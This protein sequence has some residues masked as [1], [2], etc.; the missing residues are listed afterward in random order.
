[1]F[2]MPKKKSLSPNLIMAISEE[3]AEAMYPHLRSPMEKVEMDRVIDEFNRI[4]TFQKRTIE[5]FKVIPCSDCILDISVHSDDTEESFKTVHFSID[6]LMC[7]Q[8]GLGSLCDA[9]DQT[10]NVLKRALLDK[11]YELYKKY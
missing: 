7:R 5:M 3:Q 11:I 4:N 8:L 9:I 2:I 1:M 6:D 10:S